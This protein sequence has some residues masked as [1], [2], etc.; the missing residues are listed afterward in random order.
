MTL[1]GRALVT[2]AL[3]VTSVGSVAPSAAET[4]VPL[5]RT[6]VRFDAPE[7]GGRRQPHFI[8]ERELAFEA[9]LV[10]LADPAHPSEEEPFRRH[11]LQAA[12][13][14]HIAETLL[15]SLTIAPEPTPEEITAQSEA[16]RVMLI[17][18]VR[19]EERLV[20]AALAEGISSLELR[21]LLRR[22]ARASL[23]LDRMVAPMLAPSLLEL[24]RFH[25]EGKTPFS[26]EPFEKVEA[27]LRRYYV[28]RSLS[29]TLSTYFQN[30]RARLRIE[31]L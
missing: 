14:R 2:L 16:A 30:A 23:Y 25:A 9:R 11:H 21:S 20:K 12:L 8:F 6:V 10:A 4:R 19:G 3:V 15:A 13:E 5:D 26:S 18:Q 27:P 22:R 17:E 7:T 24:R 29:T 31:F 1:F 28:A